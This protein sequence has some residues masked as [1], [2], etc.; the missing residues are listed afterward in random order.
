MLV[1]G[2]GNV[3]DNVTIQIALLALCTGRH[4][5]LVELL[6]YG[7]STLRWRNRIASLGSRKM[8]EVG[9]ERERATVEMGGREEER[10]ILKLKHNTRNLYFDGDSLSYSS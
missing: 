8:L 1:T 10:E 2:G 3:N 6:I 5:V 7:R 4:A 9:E